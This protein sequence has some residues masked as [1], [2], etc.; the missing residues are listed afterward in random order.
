[1]RKQNIITLLENCY[2][3]M[4]PAYIDNSM[5]FAWFTEIPHPLFN[6]ITRFSYKNN[7]E[8][9]I[10][11]LA[12]DTALSI[13]SHPLNN[14][15]E[16]EPILIDLGFQSTGFFPV[17]RWPVKHVEST[18]L[19]IQP[20][21][22]NPFKQITAICFGFHENIVDGW[23]RL[24]QNG[25]H[26]SYLAYLDGNPV[27][28]GTLFRV[29]KRI[30]VIFNIATLPSFQ[31]QG[32]GRAMMLHL[33]HRAHTLRLKELILESSPLAKKLY[34]DLGFKVEYDIEVFVNR[35]F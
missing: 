31:G 15:K 7:I 5:I 2:Q 19:E 13:W 23:I 29:D 9:K 34:A 8:E 32:V 14:G 18:S 11:T 1:M 35:S 10:R 26:E 28:T 25:D 22:I 30:G 24:L 21:D 3:I 27:G 20:A 6:I 12:K 16:L 17:M 4:A 33:M